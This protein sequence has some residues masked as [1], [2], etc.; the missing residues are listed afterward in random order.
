MLFKLNIYLYKKYAKETEVYSNK[1][2]LHARIFTQD[3]HGTQHTCVTKV[4][5]LLLDKKQ[6][7]KKYLI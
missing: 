3:I 5:L 1:E 4:A 6:Y 7:A 2:L